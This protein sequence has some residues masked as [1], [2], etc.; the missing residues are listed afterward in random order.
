MKKYKIIK[1]ILTIIDLLCI[2]L[3]IVSFPLWLTG[4]IPI[5]INPIMVIITLFSALA[6]TGYNTW[7]RKNFLDVDAPEFSAHV[8]FLG[9]R[10][11]PPT[12]T[13][14]LGLAQEGSCFATFLFDNN[15]VKEFSVPIAYYWCLKEGQSGLITF[16]EKD[17]KSWFVRFQSI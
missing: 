2:V 6:L 1:V 8:R 5:Y 11:S 3:L 7:Y 13:N 9:K 17:G 10:K 16:K 4:K 12:S 15:F 14:P